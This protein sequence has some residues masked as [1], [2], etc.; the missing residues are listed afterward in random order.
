MVGMRL[1]DVLGNLGVLACSDVP[2]GIGGDAGLPKISVE[3]W[4]SITTRVGP[5]ADGVTAGEVMVCRT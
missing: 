1:V 4:D 5:K 3:R 2:T